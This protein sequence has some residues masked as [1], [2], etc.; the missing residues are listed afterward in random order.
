MKSK[1]DRK[2]LNF[3][4]AMFYEDRSQRHPVTSGRV[5]CDRPQAGEYGDTNADSNDD[6]DEK[7]NDS[8]PTEPVFR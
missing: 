1:Q 2:K 5:H 3:L 6:D 8:V 7:F 4:S